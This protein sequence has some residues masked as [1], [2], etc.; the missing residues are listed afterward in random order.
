MIA[1]V[2]IT[3]LVITNHTVTFLGFPGLGS[4]LGTFNLFFHT[5]T[6]A[7]LVSQLLTFE[8]IGKP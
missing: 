7:P 6:A 1:A 8:K 3:K 4:N 2:S 5:A